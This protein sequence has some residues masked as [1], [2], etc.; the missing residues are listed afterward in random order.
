MGGQLRGVE[1]GDAVIYLAALGRTPFGP[2]KGEGVKM[3]E[4]R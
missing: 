3:G 2:L 4:Y 1:R